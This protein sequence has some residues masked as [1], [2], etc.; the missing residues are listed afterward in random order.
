MKI[1]FFGAAGEVG[2][3]C[4]M[5]STDNT[6]VLLDTGIKLGAQIEYPQISNS[7]LESVDGIFISHAHLDHIGF[8]PHIYS[9]GYKGNYFATKPTVELGNVLISDYLRISNPLGVSKKGMEDMVK[10]AKMVD[11]GKEF[12]FRDLSIKFIPAGHILGSALIE[13]R[14]RKN[15]IVYTGDI[16][17]SRTRLLEGAEIRNLKGDTLIT[18]S[19][20]ASTADVFPGEK[21]VSPEMMKS[22]KSTITSGGKV[23]VPSFAVGRAQEVLFLLDD[24]MNSGVLPKV[25]IYVDGMINKAL[26]IYRHNVIYCRKELQ[27]KILMSDYDPFKS[28]NFI[29]VDKK[30]MR[31]KIVNDTDSCIIVTTSGMLSGGPVMF[32]LSKLASSSSNK[33]LMVGYQAIGTLGRTLQEGAKHINLNGS[34]IKVEMHVET[35]HLS[36]HADR[37][38]L[39][40]LVS[41]VKDLRNIFIVHGEIT[42]SNDFKDFVAKKYNAKVP[43]LKEEHS[44]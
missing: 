2:R 10:H 17:L 4:I 35:H 9:S 37:P 31:N 26:R 30:S 24:Y 6:N 20:Y 38:Q 28:K 29:I 14:D 33:M 41:K 34:D 3:S 7:Q 18:E 13:I 43:G 5:V 22:I 1:S 27:S 19:T 44:I 40:N 42:K 12:K 23:I 32:Y 16:N 36:A 25:P 8:L 21:K 11:Y 39:E 15:G